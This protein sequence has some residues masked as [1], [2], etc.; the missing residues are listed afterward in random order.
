MVH[1]KRSAV[2]EEKAIKMLGNDAKH[3][4]SYTDSALQLFDHNFL[5]YIDHY[6]V[7][8]SF[9]NGAK[10]ILFEKD[11][12]YIQQKKSKHMVKVSHR[13][14]TYQDFL[15]DP[16]FNIHGLMDPNTKA[17]FYHSF[18]NSITPD[19]DLQSYYR[20]RMPNNSLPKQLMF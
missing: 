12:E 3:S 14:M 16:V 17:G 9:T 7:G 5:R 10:K 11:A 13:A 18:C 8:T 15:T 2:T 1:L 6:Y 19:T 20:Y 4:T